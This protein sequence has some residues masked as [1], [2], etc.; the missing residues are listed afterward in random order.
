MRVLLVGNIFGR[1]LLANFYF[2]MEKLLHG[3]ARAGHAV[4]VFNDRDTARMATPFRS[5][6]LGVGRTNRRLVQAVKNFRPDLVVLGH[7][8][9]IDNDTL[10]EIRDRVPSV[11]IIYR[12]VDPLH[13]ERNRSLV[14]RRARAVDAIFV[15]TAGQPV[16]SIE[17]G[18]TPVHFMPNP[19]DPALETLQA[20]AHTDQDHDLFFAISG[21]IDRYD[22]R[23]AMADQIRAALP[24]V[25]FDFRGMHG[26]PSQRGAAYFD[27]LQNARMGL[28]FS[29]VNDHYLY[30]SGRMAQYMGNGLLTFLDRATGFGE[31]FGEDEL[32]LY[33]SFNEL[34][35]KI[36][37][38]AR[39]D[40]ERRA[41]AQ[42]GW[43]KAHDIFD[44]RKVAD[45]IVDVTFGRE[46]SHAYA[47]PTRS[48][49]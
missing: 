15:T 41:V 10:D 42:R 31:I 13:Y 5:R 38:Y 48:W 29:R 17:T 1:E 8:E 43:Q 22:Q 4:Q 6:T 26:K 28:S 44:C 11:R 32:A 37:H 9:M 34:C 27:L 35:D 18:R 16:A 24:E 45:Y 40:D 3:F 19:V 2:T 49:S 47:W 12:N 39:H 23:I 21:A 33:G 30:S 14:A 36:R 25:A 7:C 20:F 46:P